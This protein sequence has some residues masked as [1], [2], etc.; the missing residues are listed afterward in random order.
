MRTK[1]GHRLKETVDN[2]TLPSKEERHKI[3][4]VRTY[5]EDLQRVRKIETCDEADRL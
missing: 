2:W 1:R 4:K 3:Y 5:T